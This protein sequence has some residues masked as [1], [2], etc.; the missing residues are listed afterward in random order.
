MKYAVLVLAL[1]ALILPIT[2]RADGID[3]TN[4][5]GTLTITE[6]GLVSKGSQLMSF[7]G[8]KATKGHSLGSVDFAT[9]ALVSGSIWTGGIFSDVGSSF[10]VTGVGAKGQPKGVIF[11]GAF[12]GP[13]AWTLVASHRQ[14]HEYQLTGQIAGMLWTGRY[15]TGNTTQ[16][17]YTYWN[18][19]KIDHKGSVHLGMTHLNTPEPGTLGLLG[20]GLVAIAGLVRRKVAANN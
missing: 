11:S 15:V 16:T 14:F 17:I 12:L 4:Q 19:I 6:Q 8:I 1:L 10:V 7:N 5:N 20:T 9:G 3:L 13:I 18:Q 2:A